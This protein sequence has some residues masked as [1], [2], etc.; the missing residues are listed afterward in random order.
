MLYAPLGFLR[1]LKFLGG[2]VLV[3]CNR[4]DADF[5]M[6][7]AADPDDFANA[8]QSRTPPMS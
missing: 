4:A 3:D 8:K 7:D 1:G 2:V 6:Q 5:Q